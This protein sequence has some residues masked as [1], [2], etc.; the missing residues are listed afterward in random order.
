LKGL[1]NVAGARLT[2]NV[3]K[4]YFD[5]QLLLACCAD[6][7]AAACHTAG[8]SAHGALPREM[9][10]AKSDYITTPLP[11]AGRAAMIAAAETAGAGAILCD[12]YGGAVNRI[13]TDS[14]AF[15]HRNATFDAHEMHGLPR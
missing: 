8:T 2:A 5:L 6:V 3:E 15:V 4:P 14:T 9:F 12:A 1:L 11:A 7:G 13:P 10:N